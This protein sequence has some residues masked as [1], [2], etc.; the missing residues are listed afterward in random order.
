MKNRKFVEIHLLFLLYSLTAVVCWE[1]FLKDLPKGQLASIPIAM[2][3]NVFLALVAY[4]FAVFFVCAK[5][6][7]FRIIWGFLAFLFYPNTFYMI[8]DAKHVADWFPDPRLTFQQ[9]PEIIAFV[10]LLVA[11][12]FG[13]ILGMQ[14]M[15]LVVNRFLAESWLKFPFVVVMSCL[16]SIAIYAGRIATLRLNSWDIFTR[17]IYTMSRLIGT[18]SP[19]NTVFLISFTLYQ[20]FMIA[21]VYWLVH[22]EAA[23]KA[24]KG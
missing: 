10:L 14:A 8:T 5:R 21:L 4:D 11:I 9:A 19:H 23:E 7:I 17:P 6:L 12:L 3:W 13:T 15:R 16:S 20:L 2:I 18:V 24:K 1:F 22:D